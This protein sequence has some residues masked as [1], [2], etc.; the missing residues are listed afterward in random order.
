MK[1]SALEERQTWPLGCVSRKWPW[2]I[3]L[4][5]KASLS[6][7]LSCCRFHRGSGRLCPHWPGPHLESQLARQLLAGRGPPPDSHIR[8]S[9]SPSPEAGP[10]G[11]LEGQGPGGGPSSSHA[12]P[13]HPVL[14]LGQWTKCSSLCHEPS[15]RTAGGPQPPSWF[16]ASLLHRGSS[17]L[18]SSL[19]RFGLPGVTLG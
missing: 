12:A 5:P 7:F 3:L 8:F 16:P 6:S 11:L 9:G 17:A 18:S 14:P 1:V 13:G 15:T 10:E 19:F 4:E 2:W